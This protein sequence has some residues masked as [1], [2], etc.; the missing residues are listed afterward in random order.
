[1][2]TRLYRY[3]RAITIGHRSIPLRLAS[4]RVLSGW[5]WSLSW[6]FSSGP[7]HDILRSEV[8]KGL[9]ALKEANI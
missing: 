7:Y 6:P 1:M 5:P 8:A 2:P 4:A 3:P 9:L